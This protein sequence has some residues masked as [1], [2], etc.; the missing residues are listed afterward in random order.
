MYD[1]GTRMEVLEHATFA[2][3][4]FIISLPMLWFLATSPPFLVFMACFVVGTA[5]SIVLCECET[6]PGSP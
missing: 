1:H 6:D 3:M 4:C 2:V 5:L